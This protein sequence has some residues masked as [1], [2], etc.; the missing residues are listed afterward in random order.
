MQ[1]SPVRTATW[2]R[3]YETSGRPADA[4]ASYDTAIALEPDFA[5]A[6][7]NRGNALG[8]LKRPEEALASYRKAIALKPDYAEAYLNQ[9]FCLLLLERFEQGWRQYEWRKQGDKPIAAR[10]FP[11]PLW[12]GEEDIAGKTL[13]LWYEQGFGDTIQFC[14]YATL[15]EGARREGRHVGAAAIACAAERELPHDPDHRSGRSANR[16]RLS[17]SV[18][19]LAARL[20]NDDRDNPGQYSVSES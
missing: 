13:F 11:Q 7:N 15:A 10:T 4:L 12:L 1:K 18:A 14:R 20:C 8:D 16:F 6:H 17:L 3:H 5:M 2:A 19:E 9:A